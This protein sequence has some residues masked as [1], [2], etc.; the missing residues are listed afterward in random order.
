MLPALGVVPP[1]IRV[2]LPIMHTNQQVNLIITHLILIPTSNNLDYGPLKSPTSDDRRLGRHPD[3]IR[4]R[5]AMTQ[6][7]TLKKINSTPNILCMVQWSFNQNSL[8]I[9]HGTWGSGFKIHVKTN[10]KEYP[11]FTLATIKTMWH[12]YKGV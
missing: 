3:T 10:D 1:I 2:G 4:H 8:K 7:T 6:K 5:P 11:R 12:W 9:S